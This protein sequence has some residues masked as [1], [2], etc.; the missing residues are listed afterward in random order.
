MT[1]QELEYKNTHKTLDTIGSMVSFFGWVVVV[2]GVITILIG[3]GITGIGNNL[4]G[5]VGGLGVLYGIVVILV[6]ILIVGN[7]Q[8]LKTI[9]LIEKNTQIGY[10]VNLKLLNKLGGDI[11]GHHSVEPSGLKE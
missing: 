11:E 1:L 10:R 5:F 9:G 4:G 7:G 3:L 6:G 2:F 8:L